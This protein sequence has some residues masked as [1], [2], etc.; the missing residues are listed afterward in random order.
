MSVATGCGDADA[1][2]RFRLKTAIFRLGSEQSERRTPIEAQTD[3]VQLDKQTQI[4]N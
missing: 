3:A 1:F 2:V 4:R